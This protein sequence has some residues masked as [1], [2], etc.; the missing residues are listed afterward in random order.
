MG[1]YYGGS[2]TIQV[3]TTEKRLTRVRCNWPDMG[4]AIRTIAG[5]EYRGFAYEALREDRSD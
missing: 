5:R 4:P 2:V 1:L 3:I